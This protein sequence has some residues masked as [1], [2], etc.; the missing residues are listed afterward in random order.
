MFGKLLSK[1]L[2]A[3]FV[4]ATLARASSAQPLDGRPQRD[5]DGFVFCLVMTDGVA[6]RVYADPVGRAVDWEVQNHLQ[7]MGLTDRRRPKARWGID[8]AGRCWQRD[9]LGYAFY[10]D[11]CAGCPLRSYYHPLRRA[12]AGRVHDCLSRVDFQTAVRG[13]ARAVAVRG[14]NSA[15]VDTDQIRQSVRDAVVRSLNE[16]RPDSGDL[17]NFQQLVQAGIEDALV[18]AFNQIEV[19]PPP[20]Q[21]ASGDHDNDEQDNA[22]ANSDLPPANESYGET[23]VVSAG[24]IVTDGNILPLTGGDT[25]TVAVLRDS[26]ELVDVWQDGRRIAAACRFARYFED[27]RAIANNS[28][29]RRIDKAAD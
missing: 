17:S 13:A 3:W 11:D 7:R 9:E 8:A 20:R 29:A 24:W 15:E 5:E 25:F 4:L 14:F 22:G 28:H 21:T 23:T 12:V 16:A 2:L 1:P 26:P 6:R 18:E 27:A 10:V 19:T